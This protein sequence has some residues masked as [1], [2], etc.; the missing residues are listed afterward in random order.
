MIQQN[1]PRKK[2]CATLLALCMPGL[3]QV[4]NGELIKAACLLLFF[5]ATPVL[6]SETAAFLPAGALIGT[7]AAAIGSALAIY[8]FAITDAFKTSGHK[9]LLYAPKAYNNGFF[10]LAMFIVGFIGL[11]IAEHYIRT[12]IVTPY[13]IPSSSMEPTILR[14]DYVFADRKVYQKGP[15]HV[16][17]IVIHVFPDDRSKVYIRQI[18]ALPGERLAY[19]DGTVVTAPHGTVLVRGSGN[20]GTVADSRQFGPVDMRDIVGQV[21]QIYF[22]RG[23][24]GIRWQRIGKLLHTWEGAASTN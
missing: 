1:I 12:Q 17:D 10:Y 11:G 15:V 3:G 7:V 19:P 24:E 18:A 21:R 5:A 9:N 6:I 4:Y 20:G 16:G 14:G 8:L 22:S 2:L 23:P 13:V